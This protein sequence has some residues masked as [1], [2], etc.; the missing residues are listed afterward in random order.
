MRC[1]CVSEVNK[2]LTAA[3]LSRSSDDVTR[4]RSLRTNSEKR[5]Q[6]FEFDRGWS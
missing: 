6:D 1:D 4:D 3:R 2:R 5:N